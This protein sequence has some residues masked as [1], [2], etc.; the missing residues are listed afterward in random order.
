MDTEPLNGYEW[1]EV[2]EDEAYAANC[3]TVGNNVIL[4]AGFPKLEQQIQQ[5]G[6]KTLPVEMSEF[7]KVDGGVTCLSLLI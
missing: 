6:F 7:Q 5:H 2:D 3:L 4:P 1:I